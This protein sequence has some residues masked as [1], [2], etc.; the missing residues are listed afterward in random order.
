MVKSG[1][2]QICFTNPAKS[3]SGRISQKQIRYSPTYAITS[4]SPNRWLVTRVMGVAYKKSVR[5]VG[6]FS[7]ASE[8]IWI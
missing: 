7:D 5:K 1:S 4:Y 8:Q 2:G 3:G 6:F